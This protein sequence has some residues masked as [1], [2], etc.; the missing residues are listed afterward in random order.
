MQKASQIKSIIEGFKLG[1]LG[2]GT[3]RLSSDTTESPSVPVVDKVVGWANVTG[4]SDDSQFVGGYAWH[5]SNEHNFLMVCFQIRPPD[6][7][8]ALYEIRIFGGKGVTFPTIK[9]TAKF[10]GHYHYVSYR[11]FFTQDHDQATKELV[12]VFNKIKATGSFG[13]SLAD[14]Q[15]RTGWTVIEKT[16][17]SFRSYVWDRA[18]LFKNVYFNYS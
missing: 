7:N 3:P 9:V 17:G 13:K 1:K 4:D 18:H 5:E 10:P 12:D 16:T 2:A 15:L 14:G 11:R 6:K 8:L